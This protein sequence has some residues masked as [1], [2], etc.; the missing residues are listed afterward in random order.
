MESVTHCNGAGFTYAHVSAN[1]G[2]EMTEFSTD[3]QCARKPHGLTDN[4]LEWC[5]ANI[6]HFRQSEADVVAT[7]AAETAHREAMGL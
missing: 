1:R 2:R 3:T 4:Q 6:P 7:R 5:R